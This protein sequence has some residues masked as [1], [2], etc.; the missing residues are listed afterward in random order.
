MD[1]ELT[2][3]C[4]KYYNQTHWHRKLEKRFHRLLADALPYTGQ[5]NVNELDAIIRCNR[6]IQK[7]RDE[8]EDGKAAMQKTAGTILRVLE[9][10]EIQPNTKLTC[11]VP[12]EFELQ[13][14][15]DE[16]NAVYCTKTKD[17]NPLKDD[18]SVIV[19]KLVTD[20]WEMD[21]ED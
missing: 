14:W 20:P 8:A 7:A 2:N 1:G 5:T 4:H 15:A 3:L 18:P 21:E 13:V 6:E 12:G 9:Y 17:L 11:E 16:A 10:F 19:I